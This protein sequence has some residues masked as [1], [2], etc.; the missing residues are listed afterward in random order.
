[1][2]V[3]QVAVPAS[4]TKSLNQIVRNIFI[5]VPCNTSKS[6]NLHSIKIPS[7]LANQNQVNYSRFSA[8]T[9]MTGT[10]LFRVSDYDYVGFDLDNT[11]LQYKVRILM[12]QYAFSVD[13]EL[14]TFR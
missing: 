5:S 14:Y 3:R 1:M 9:I 12:N 2:F 7:H 13:R 11:L 4:R 6:S 8:T 10:D